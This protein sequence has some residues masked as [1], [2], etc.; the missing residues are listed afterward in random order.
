MLFTSGT[1]SMSKGVTIR[2]YNI[3]HAVE[4]Y[5]KVLGITEEDKAIIPVPIYLVTGL[6]AVFG[7]MIHIGGTV[8]LNRFF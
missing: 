7:L 5:H 2:N 1:T 8:C 3:M 6:V 4:S